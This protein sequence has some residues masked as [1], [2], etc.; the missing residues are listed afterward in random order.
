MGSTVG[1]EVVVDHLVGSH[2]L[3]LAFPALLAQ[4][5]LDDG[6]GLLA[7]EPFG[8]DEADHGV[9]GVEQFV[10]LD[11]LRRHGGEVLE[12]QGGLAARLVVD[13][14]KQALL[15]IWVGAGLRSLTGCLR[16]VKTSLMFLFMSTAM[17]FLLRLVA[18]QSLVVRATLPGQSGMFMTWQNLSLRA[19]LL[20]SSCEM[21]AREI[22]RSPRWGRAYSG[23][24]RPGWR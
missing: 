6:L 22:L 15:L 14:P 1:L 13:E 7:G 8:E 16:R 19:L 21:S 18:G 2:A 3:V 5:G 10:D 4:R 12:L 9:D 24:R 23:F 20:C 17:L 11:D